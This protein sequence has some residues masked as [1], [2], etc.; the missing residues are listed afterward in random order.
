MKCKIMEIEL[1]EVSCVANGSVCDLSTQS[2]SCIGKPNSQPEFRPKFGSTL[3]IQNFTL[4]H[5]NPLN[6]VQFLHFVSRK[7]PKK[8]MELIN[9]LPTILDCL[10]K[11]ELGGQG[12]FNYRNYYISR[13]YL[14][15]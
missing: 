5:R 7:T 13:G 3:D 10:L 14:G 6:P 12:T 4:Y 15:L 9:T 11:L 8:G 1:E 2:T